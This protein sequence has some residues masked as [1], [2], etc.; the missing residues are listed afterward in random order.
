VFLGVEQP[1]GD[2]HLVEVGVR[3]EHRRLEFW[4]FQPKRP[5]RTA[6]PASSTAT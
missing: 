2:A 3:R 5:T 6:P 1:V 4:F